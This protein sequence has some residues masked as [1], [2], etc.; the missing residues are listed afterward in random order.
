MSLIVGLIVGVIVGWVVPKPS[1]VQSLQ[2][3][4]KGLISK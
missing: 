1:I 2:D 3:K 4:I